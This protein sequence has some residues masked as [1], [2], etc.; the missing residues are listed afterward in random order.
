MAEQQRF[1]ARK[2]S[3]CPPDAIV[4]PFIDEGDAVEVAGKMNAGSEYHLG[5]HW[6][7]GP[8]KSYVYDDNDSWVV[9]DTQPAE[10][11]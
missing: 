10:V 11:E 3:E 7:T 9:L 2:A 4:I 5:H 6:A 1:V 8:A